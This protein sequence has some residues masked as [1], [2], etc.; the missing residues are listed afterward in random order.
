MNTL[1][2]YSLISTDRYT[3]A[4]NQ[5]NRKIS[6]LAQTSVLLLCSQLPSLLPALGNHWSSLS[7]YISFSLEFCINGIIEC[8]LLCLPAFAQQDVFEVH[9]CL[10]VYQ[11][12][13]SF[14]CWI[15]LGCTDMPQLVYPSPLMGV[16]VVSRL[17]LYE[18]AFLYKSVFVNTC[19][20]ISGKYLGVTA[21]QFY[22]ALVP[23][24]VPTSHIQCLHIS[25]TT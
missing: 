13:V 14:C 3:Y 23:F 1:S 10:C 2:G 17:G 18:T 20:H 11:Y 15:V 6:S 7:L 12:F 16:W 22:K 21:M 9:L 25:A 19:F 24:Y 5:E 8:N 4:H